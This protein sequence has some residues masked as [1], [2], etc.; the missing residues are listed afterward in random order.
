VAVIGADLARSDLRRGVSRF[1]SLRKPVGILAAT[2]IVIVAWRLAPPAPHVVS[3]SWLVSNL[4]SPQSIAS[5]GE[6]AGE[7]FSKTA[8]TC[9]L[10]PFCSRKT[11]TP[12]STVK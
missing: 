8:T 1:A 12:V 9:H 2:A 10:L 11:A 5:R 7:P 6:T 4:K 3:T